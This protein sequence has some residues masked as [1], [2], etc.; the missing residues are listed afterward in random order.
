MSHSVSP[1]RFFRIVPTQPT[2][3][4][5]TFLVVVCVGAI[6]IVQEPSRSA[7]AMVP[8]LLLQLFAASSGFEVP[9]RRGHYDLLLT[10]GQH[11]VWMALVHW[12]T[13]SAP[14]VLAWLMLATIET[15][16]TGGQTRLLAS[17]TF[18]AMGLVSTL[19][20]AITVRLPRFSGG[21]GWLLALAIFT[22]VLASGNVPGREP[23]ISTDDF[24][25]SAWGFLVY[26]VAFV[27]RELGIAEGLIAAPA[28]MV[29]VVSMV[30][31]CRWVSHAS[32]PLE[33][34]Q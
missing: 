6:A 13:S 15:M 14:G 33:A 7:G 8:V 30:A 21:I 23:A 22:S 28:L 17:G 12:M 34:A 27:G 25:G 16:S 1:L 11:R 32:V 3:M 10:S 24:L 20:W 31:A 26:P 18:A 9:A 5:W 29:S 4:I 19:P 2:L